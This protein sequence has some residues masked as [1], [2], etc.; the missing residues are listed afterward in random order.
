LG[1]QQAAK[2]VKDQDVDASVPKAQTV[3]RSESLTPDHIVV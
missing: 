2:F 3:R 1:E